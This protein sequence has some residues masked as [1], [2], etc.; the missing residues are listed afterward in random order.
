VVV[1]LDGSPAA[2][3]ALPLA[4]VVARQLGA[5]I[6]LLHVAP[7][8]RLAPEVLQQL[9]AA[10]EGGPV[11][12]L[13]WVVGDPVTEILAVVSDPSVEVVVLTTHGRTVV[14]EGYLGRVAEAVIA[15]TVHPILLVRPE[16]AARIGPAV[17]ELRRLLL[18]LN[19]TPTTAAAL[20][21]AT[22]LASRLG[23]SIDLLYV[24]SPELKPPLERG[25]IGA[26][27]YVDQPQ[28]E[29]PAWAQ[30]VI[31]RLCRCFAECPA[32][33]PV[34]MHFAYGEIGTAI[35]AF[36]AE[37]AV[38]AIALVRRSRLEPGHAAVLR[39]VLLATPCP[40]L[41]VSG[42][43]FADDV[44]AAAESPGLLG[45][46]RAQDEPVGGAASQNSVDVVTEASLESF[47]AS[48]APGWIADR[49]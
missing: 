5:P 41:L 40:I 42:P 8:L 10:L 38:D 24:A 49:T 21:P 20:R 31:E 6:E 3:T 45:L 23:A 44:A 9:P 16:A 19:G 35:T 37:H 26:P 7:S 36:A 28:H 30:E 14:P 46:A 39:A 11:R 13:R 22:D 4:Q 12:Q 1:A 47:P 48:D 34:A 25:S 2:A 33:V 15:G 32:S 17:P 27:R 18:P 43:S 29:W